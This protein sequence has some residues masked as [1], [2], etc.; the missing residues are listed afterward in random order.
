[1]ISR[2]VWNIVSPF[3]MTSHKQVVLVDPLNPHR[4]SA[5]NNQHDQVPQNYPITNLLAEDLEGK[6]YLNGVSYVKSVIQ[7]ANSYA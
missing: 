1:M 3:G 6:C 7:L 5:L 2:N 4:D